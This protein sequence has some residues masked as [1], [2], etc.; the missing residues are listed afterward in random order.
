MASW[1]K[2][3]A[4]GSAPLWAL[5]SVNKAPTAANMGPAGSGKLFNNATADNLITNITRGLFN[6]TAGEIPAGAH[7]GW[8]LKTTGKSGSGRTG[9][10]QVE[11]L[12]CLTSNS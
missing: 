12:V 1:G 4:E 7:Q 9:R 5:A 2:T 11:T 3:D 6:Y 10:V 8:V